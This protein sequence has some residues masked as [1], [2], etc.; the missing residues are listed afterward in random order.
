M[1]KR[2]LS[3]QT[4]LVILAAA[5]VSRLALKSFNPALAVPQLQQDENTV[6]YN[7]RRRLSALGHGGGAAR[8]W[9]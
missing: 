7:L 3:D 4:R 2:I 1:L 9:A 6:L 5:R 8:Y